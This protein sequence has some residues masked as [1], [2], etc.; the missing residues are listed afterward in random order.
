LKLL[1]FVDPDLQSRAERYALD[2]I[3]RGACEGGILDE[4]NAR[5][6]L[7]VRTLLKSAGSREVRVEARPPEPGSC[8]P[9]LTL[10]PPP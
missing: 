8:V 2:R 7:T 10:P 9:P 6:E 5:A 3:L 4:A 1:S